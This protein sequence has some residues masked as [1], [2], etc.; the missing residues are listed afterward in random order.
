MNGDISWCELR[1]CVIKHENEW[2]AVNCE[3]YGPLYCE[4]IE[5]ECECEGAWFCEDIDALTMDIMA[6]YD[7]NGD[8]GISIYD[9]LEV[10]K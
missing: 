8:Q 3:N 1:N 4:D 2:R 10:E 7:T 9:E 5:R 6:M